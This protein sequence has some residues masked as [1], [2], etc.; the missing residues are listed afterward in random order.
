MA[1]IHGKG[2]NITIG[3]VDLTAFANN[4]E[5]GREAEAHDST[6]FGNGSKVYTGGLKDGSITVSGLYDSAAGGPRATLEPLL[7]TTVTVVYKPEGTGT[8]KPTKTVPAVMKTYNESAPVADMVTWTSEYQMS[9]DV[10]TTT[11]P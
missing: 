5:F 6:T 11:G 9:G 4:V 10:V 8:G 3:A 2:V 1:K 7:G